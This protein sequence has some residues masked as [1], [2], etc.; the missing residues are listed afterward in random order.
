[1]EI[2]EIPPQT[3]V[4]AKDPPIT[5]KGKICLFLTA[6]PLVA[7]LAYIVKAHLLVLGLWHLAAENLLLISTFLGVVVGATAVTYLYKEHKAS[8]VWLGI[9]GTSGLSA[10]IWAC[11]LNADPLLNGSRPVSV[12]VAVMVV[13]A[14]IAFSICAGIHIKDKHLSTIEN[15]T[16]FY[17]VAQV[18]TV[19]VAGF[20]TMILCDID[21]YEARK[22]AVKE[23]SVSLPDKESEQ[24]IDISIGSYD[25]E[26]RW[27]KWK[28][29]SCSSK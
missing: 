18:I 21:E 29:A 23:F 15:I 11:I 6:G 16:A 25:F 19:L 8:H 1:M 17:I 20:T 28:Q 24:L 2:S 22:Q 12:S 7:L 5:T 27:D 13:I 14:V 4:E 3:D 10:I 26:C 9:L